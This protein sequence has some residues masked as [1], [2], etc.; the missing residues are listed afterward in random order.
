MGVGNVSA[1]RVFRRPPHQRGT[2]AFAVGMHR[3][4]GRTAAT[5]VETFAEHEPHR[6]VPDFFS[7][8][9]APNLQS[10]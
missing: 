7:S 2:S 8:D 4:L 3:D 10:L 5:S 9:S 1:G 6:S